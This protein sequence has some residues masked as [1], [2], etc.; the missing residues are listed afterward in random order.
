MITSIDDFKNFLISLVRGIVSAGDAK[1]AAYKVQIDT[2]SADLTIANETIAELKS[3]IAA[4]DLA[5]AAIKVET[6]STQ[7]AAL[8]QLS[9]DL[10]AEFN[11]TLTADAVSE[12][13]TVEPAIET[14]VEVT[15]ATE[16]GTSEPTPET[17]VESAIVAIEEAGA[18]LE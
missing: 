14:P 17:V 2:L 13:V 9:T 7:V 11:P 6:A 4:N 16:I 8:D 10:A 3:A 5:L 1:L 15:E 18:D 12:A